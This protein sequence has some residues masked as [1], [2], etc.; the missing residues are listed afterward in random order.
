M[1]LKTN[2]DDTYRSTIN[3]IKTKLKEIANDKEIAEFCSK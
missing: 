3:L 1:V 2:G